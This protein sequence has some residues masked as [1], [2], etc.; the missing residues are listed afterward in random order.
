MS[1]NIKNYIFVFIRIFFF[2][3]ALTISNLSFATVVFQ[4][5]IPDEI[6]VNISWKSLKKYNDF[7]RKIISE[8][9][10][11]PIKEKYKKN[12]SGKVYFGDNKDIKALP[13]R[14]R[15]TGDLKDH[16]DYE[17]G[18]TSLKIKLLKGNLGH[19]VR[20]RILIPG[21]KNFYDEIFWSSL[22]ETLGYPSLYKKIIKVNLNGIITQ[23]FLFEEIPSKEFL[24]RFK[25]RESP[26]IEA[27]ER[28]FWK[29]NYEFRE[30]CI[31]M[32][33]NT[34]V[35]S[36][37]QNCMKNIKADDHV[38]WKVD[39]KAF[40]KNETAALIA[41]NSLYK[42]YNEENNFNENETIKK[43]DKLNLDYNASHGLRKHNRKFIYDPILNNFIPIY[44]DGDIILPIKC[45][46]GENYFK[47]KNLKKK[48]EEFQN[49]YV[50]R[51]KISLKDNQKCAA[52]NI[53]T[54]KYNYFFKREMNTGNDLIKTNVSNKIKDSYTLNFDGLSKNYKICDHE[55]N[56]EKINFSDVKRILS[57]Q[58][59]KEIKLRKSKS[60]LLKKKKI[61]T[62]TQN[63]YVENFLDK[64]RFI[65]KEN[66]TIFFKDSGSIKN[67]EIY[68]EN[69]ISSKF[70]IY[71]SD[72]KNT[73]IK[74]ISPDD[75]KILINNYDQNLLTG[76]L[77]II[78]SKIKINSI[79]VINAK[80][81]DG[82]NFI[83]VDGKVKTINI[84]NS[85]SDS[86]DAD[87]SRIDFEEIFV[88]NSKNDCVDF[89]GGNYQIKKLNVKNCG[90]KGLSV[91]EK[92][93]VNVLNFISEFNKIDFV[94]KDSSKLYLNKFVSNKKSDEICGSA[95]N[96]KQE[97]NG[98][99]IIF[100]RKPT[101]I[102]EK[103]KFSE[104]I[105]KK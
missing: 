87:F 49:I 8:E 44:F 99:K 16:I 2:I 9:Y 3:W 50:E 48:F 94:S 28:L 57:G 98:G 91:G 25:Y 61:S 103:D 68:L 36:Q 5:Q 12:F 62:D 81:E 80:C 1:Q 19:I 74:L 85:S 22:I 39:N 27:D 11:L 29:I 58:D 76:C 43:F 14:I 53:L 66:Q 18:I 71:G 90:D 60:I 69:A 78:N 65:V 47:N 13:A 77:T 37:E 40:I 73:K 21:T 33:L 7:Y 34:V 23:N 72:L 56:C 20:F 17:K 4:P 102:L 88:S 96:K 83:D 64:K 97:F 35:I 92:S 42:I 26:I 75:E 6:G 31:N 82:V 30:K 89:S 59:P 95:Y 70:V 32:F 54:N 24:E 93:D 86:L 10:G 63:I 15:I 52:Q 104:I 79:E 51:A 55:K 84:K 100:Q 46:V 41:F 45:N 101:C 105:F 67:L 38:G